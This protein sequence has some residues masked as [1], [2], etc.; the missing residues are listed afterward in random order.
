MSAIG[1]IGFA[2]DGFG[3]AGF[4]VPGFAVGGFGVGIGLFVRAAVDGAA[5]GGGEQLITVAPLHIPSATS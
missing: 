4:A 3:V 2:V 1:P 5:V